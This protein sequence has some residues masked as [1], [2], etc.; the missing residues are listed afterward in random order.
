MGA[1]R[2]ILA[3]VLEELDTQRIEGEIEGFEH[4][5]PRAI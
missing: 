4:C 5:S 3:L 2:K 1:G